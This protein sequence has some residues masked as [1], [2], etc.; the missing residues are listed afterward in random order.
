MRGSAMAQCLLAILVMAGFVPMVWAG[1]E[2]GQEEFLKGLLLARRENAVLRRGKY[3]FNEVGIDPAR[4]YPRNTDARPPQDWLYTL[5]RYNDR[6]VVLGVA[7]LFRRKVT[8]GLGLPLDRHR[9]GPDKTYQ[10]RPITY[11]FQ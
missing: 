5:V 3:L 2:K 6:S 10:L 11:D 4:K 9:I 1:Q 8:Y 7:S